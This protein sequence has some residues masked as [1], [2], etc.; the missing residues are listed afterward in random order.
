MDSSKILKK[1][2]KVKSKFQIVK[3]SRI[4]KQDLTR[5]RKILRKFLKCSNKREI[6]IEGK[7]RKSY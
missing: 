1:R 6:M 4:W 7:V 3:E 2:K 5:W